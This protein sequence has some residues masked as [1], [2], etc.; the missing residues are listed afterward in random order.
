M[1]KI[2]RF[3]EELKAGGEGSTEQ[4]I[5][6]ILTHHRGR[7]SCIILSDFLSEGNLKAAFNRLTG[8]GLEIMGLQIMS[9]IELD[10]ELNGDVRLLDSEIENTLDVSSV[11]DL[12]EIYHEYRITHQQHIENL[13]RQRG[14][15]FASICSETAL[16]DIVFQQLLRKGWIK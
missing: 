2:F 14:G 10:P 7:G 12:L 3:L 8:S 9:N 5:E 15:K 1:K 6:D 16:Q 4:A 13:C 11:N